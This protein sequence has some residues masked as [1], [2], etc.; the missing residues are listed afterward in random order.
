MFISRNVFIVYDIEL[1]WRVNYLP[2]MFQ[3]ELNERLMQFL[4]NQ[5]NIK[6]LLIIRE[7]IFD[8]TIMD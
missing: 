3:Q 5:C 6:V 7:N 1:S 2:N 4:N 8:D